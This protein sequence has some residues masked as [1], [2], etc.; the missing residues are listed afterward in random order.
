MH[1][2]H[3]WLFR[4]MLA[5]YKRQCLSV[6]P[7]VHNQFT[8]ID[9]NQWKST[10]INENQRKSM[11]INEHHCTSMQI[12]GNQWKSMKINGNQWKSIKINGNQWKSMKI[13]ENQW[14][15]IKIHVTKL[16]TSFYKREH[17]YKKLCL[18]VRPSTHPK[19]K[20]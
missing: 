5:L 19:C 10:E 20:C 18:S 4:C 12:N 16:R 9:N 6:C 7:S 11:E 15:S 17:L 1:I 14:K 8:K 13:N 3:A 2:V